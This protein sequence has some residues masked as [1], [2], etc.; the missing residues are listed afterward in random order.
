MRPL[1]L[2]MFVFSFFMAGAREKK[3][4]YYPNGKVQYEYEMEGHLF[5]GRFSSYFETGKL[6]I[7]GQFINNQKTGH[8]RVWDEKGLLRSERNYT[9]NK[10]FSVVSETDS[11]GTKIRRDIRQV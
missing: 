6:R 2:F 3:T 1:L 11:T 8:W 7:K 5:D 9:N 4:V 10:N